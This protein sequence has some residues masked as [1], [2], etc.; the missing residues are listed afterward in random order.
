MPVDGTAAGR[1][2]RR[3]LGGLLRRTPLTAVLFLLAALSLAGTPPFSGFFG[4]LALIRAGVESEAWIVTGVSIA[5]SVLTLYSMTKIWA[6]VFWGAPTEPPPRVEAH[7]DGPLRATRLM[8][9]STVFLV[10]VTL[11]IAVLAQRGI[12]PIVAADPSPARRAL[13][14]AMGAH[15]VVDP[16]LEP[17]FDAWARAGTG[18]QLATAAAAIHNQVAPWVESIEIEV[19]GDTVVALDRGALPGGRPLVDPD[20][21]VAAADAGDDLLPEGTE[22]FDRAVALSC[23]AAP[24]P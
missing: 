21:L 24:L 11:L 8:N 15:E 3:R 12:E 6:G 1:A 16:G 20:H 19:D 23:S 10:G 7:G 4:K 13:A 17:A 5:V 9:L 22:G 18:R 2:L 14:S